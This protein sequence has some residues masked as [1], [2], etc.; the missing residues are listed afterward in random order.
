VNSM[1]V[2]AGTPVPSLTRWGLSPDADLVYRLLVTTGPGT[3]E[4]LSRSLGITPHRVSG[5]LEE[6]HVAAAAGPRGHRTDTAASAARRWE[7]RP[8][9]RVLA[10]LRQRRLRTV[11][12]RHQAGFHHALM[13]GSGLPGQTPPPAAHGRIL[14]DH[15][16]RARIAT[17][18]GAE[19]H[20]H[21]AANPERTFPPDVATAALPL[22]RA[23]MARGVHVRTCGVPPPDGDRSCAAVQHLAAL[24][25]DYRE[26]PDVPV[27]LMVFDRRIALLPVDPLNLSAGALEIDHAVI[28]AGLVALFEKLWTAGRDPR[29]DGV[30]PIMLTERERAILALLAEGLTDAAAAE[31]LKISRR[32]IAYTLRTLMDRVGVENRFQLGLTLGSMHLLTQSDHRAGPN[33]GEST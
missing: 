12:L 13:Q 31:R 15:E 25:A 24:G 8:V 17:M 3:V 20:E 2:R 21:L 6:L 10:T 16:V 7:A 22:D 11:N 29:R 1:N 4:S 9:D 33:T 27:K 30:P 26:R 32:T 23:L 19:R 18:A 28:V 14:I 5:A